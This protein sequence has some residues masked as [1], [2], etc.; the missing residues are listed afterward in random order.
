MKSD[1]IKM[2]NSNTVDWQLLYTIG[3]SRGMKLSPEEFMAGAGFINIPEIV[4]ELD[5]QFELTTLYRK[6]GS[7]VKVIE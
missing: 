5:K 6:D 3:S 1:Y 4:E 7:F 2:R